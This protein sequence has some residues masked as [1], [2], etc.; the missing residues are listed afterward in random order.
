MSNEKYVPAIARQPPPQ[1]PL[2]TIDAPPPAALPLMVVP[3]I[4]ER[5]SGKD[6][7][8]ATVERSK[9]MTAILAALAVGIMWKFDTD[10]GTTILIFAALTIA[11]YW[12]LNRLDYTHSASGLERHRINRSVD[13]RRVELDYSYRLKYMAMQAYLKMME[14]HYDHH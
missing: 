1:M 2:M 14:K 7:A 6:R 13:I 8:S 11:G 3:Q 9:P 12:L 10:A 5:T 4:D